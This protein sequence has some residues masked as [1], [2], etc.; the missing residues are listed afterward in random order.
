MQQPE[1][2]QFREHLIGAMPTVSGYIRTF[3]SIN[4]R[5]DGAITAGMIE[6]GRMDAEA[7][8]LF[9]PLIED[10]GGTRS[11]YSEIQ[12]RLVD[13]I[14]AEM[15]RKVVFELRDSAAF[16]INI[17]KRNLFERTAD[18]GYLA[19]DSD[20]VDFLRRVRDG[21]DAGDLRAQAAHL[22]TRLEDY[23]HEYT[24]YD[25]I[26]VLDPQGRVRANLDPE[27]TVTASRDPLLRRTL[28]VDLHDGT[29]ADKYVETF[30]PTDLRPGRGNCLVY[31]QK[32]EDPASHE[33]LGVLCLCFDFEDEMRGIFGDLAQ[34]NPAMQWAVLDEGGAVIATSSQEILPQGSK[35]PLDLR[36]QFRVLEIGG[37]LRLACTMATDG[38]QGFYGL[39]WYGLAVIDLNTAFQVGG[40]GNGNGNGNGASGALLQNVSKSLT[41]I[42]NESD[43]LLADM[44]LDSINGQVKAAKFKADGFVEVLRFVNLIGDSID[45]LFHEAIKNLQHTVVDSLFNDVQFRAFQGNN[46]ADRNLYER[47]NDVCWW[48]L[49]PLFRELLA[50]HARG[51]LG[52]QELAALTDSLQYINDL[53]TPYL[54]LVLAD[55]RGRV[56]ACS[57]PPEGLREVLVQDGLPSGQDLVGLDLDQQLVRTALQLPSDK[58]YCVSPFEPTPLYGGRPTSIY[59]TAV[60]DPEHQAQTVGVIQIVFD[61][62]P[63]FQAMLHD[64]LPKGGGEQGQRR[65]FAVFT[66]REGTVISST[67]ADQPAGRRLDLPEAALKL[68]NGQRMSTV[69]HLE[70]GHY[71][72]GAQASDGYREYKR[73][74]GHCRD[75]LCLVFVPI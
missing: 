29:T 58:D 68:G 33:D 28:A 44:K 32:I 12:N 38:Y 26:I 34:G 61:S 1:V 10:M 43:G 35:V 41:G 31:S 46:I 21:L 73:S 4:K 5:W 17:L 37:S 72:L 36:S 51:G 60:R 53:Y 59:S 3:R 71:V 52:S 8:R 56:I 9:G 42:K 45:G 66:D 7:G 74:D 64:V 54:R 55:A 27:N 20:I 16:T 23:R 40:N 19:T 50:K 75:M 11:K 57:N 13:A 48:A 2:D 15:L 18:V 22:R 6:T 67:H 69:V 24:V 30:R 70:N 25:E 62:E 39:T 63:Q 14:L 49:T 47:A 65:S